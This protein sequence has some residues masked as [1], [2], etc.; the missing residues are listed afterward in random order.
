MLS[1]EEWVAEVHRLDSITHEL[2]DWMAYR[3]LQ[4]GCGEPG[5]MR[6]LTEEQEDRADNDTE[7]RELRYLRGLNQ[8]KLGYLKENGVLPPEDLA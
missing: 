5:P 6:R 1:F 7:M 2:E 3:M 8:S 4:I